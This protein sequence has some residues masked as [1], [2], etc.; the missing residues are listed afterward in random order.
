MLGESV[1]EATVGAWR[2]QE[3][4]AVAAGEVL[5]ELETDK[6]NAEV[7]ADR[8]G[9]LERIVH[10]EGDTVHPGDVLA[11][12][13]EAP[14]AAPAQAAAAPMAGGTPA[15]APASAT[16]TPASTAPARDGGASAPSE[17]A[18]ASAT[19]T[20]ASAAPARNGG[21]SAPSETAPASATA[22]PANA[23]PARAEQASPPISAPPLAATPQA[24]PLAQRLAAERHVDLAQVHG[25][26]PNGRIL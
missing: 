12:I 4:Q 5:V 7:A 24:T 10:A 18:P 6:V 15:S 20:P 14:P 21:A 25:S 17:T 11:T 8:A 1:L 2:K 22:T 9:T 23:A 19:A 13:A 26:G 3:G 16:A